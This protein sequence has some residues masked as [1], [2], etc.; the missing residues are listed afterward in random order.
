MTYDQCPQC[1]G[2]LL[3]NVRQLD[4]RR[5]REYSC[6]ACRWGSSVEEKAPADPDAGPDPQP[7]GPDRE[8]PT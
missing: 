7:G 5:I 8:P 3:S 6:P 2:N 1:G 4:G